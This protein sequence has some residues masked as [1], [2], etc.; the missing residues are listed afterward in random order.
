MSGRPEDALRSLTKSAILRFIH[1]AGGKRVSMLFYEDVRTLI[2]QYLESF[3][4][5]A[6]LIMLY[7]GRKTLQSRDAFAVF[8]IKGVHPV[9]GFNDK[10]GFDGNENPD[11]VKRRKKK[12]LEVTKQTKPKIAP[13]PP[14]KK[15]KKVQPKKEK[16]VIDKGKAKKGLAAGGIKKPH[17]FRPGTVTLRKIRLQQKSTRFIFPLS[18]FKRVIREY[19]KMEDVKPRISTLFFNITQFY[20][21][22]RVLRFLRFAIYAAVHAGRITLLP[23]DIQFARRF[24]VIE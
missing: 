22:N 3:L 12:K 19:A 13:K 14:P 6:V 23:K 8:D 11:R 5:P 9:A 15:E 7:A 24:M 20:I 4:Q 18:S 21:E 16:E 17:R 1:R 2:G 10:G